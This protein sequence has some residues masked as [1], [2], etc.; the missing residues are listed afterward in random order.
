M[1]IF[2]LLLFCFVFQM[3]CIFVVKCIICE[4][5]KEIEIVSSCF[6]G[7]IEILVVVKRKQC[8]IVLDDCLERKN[9]LLVY[10]CVFYVGF[11][12]FVEV[13]VRIWIF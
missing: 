4:N 2:L 10:Y 13:C 12:R 3:F 8:E 6:I 1:F 7:I 5:V 9:C 11:L